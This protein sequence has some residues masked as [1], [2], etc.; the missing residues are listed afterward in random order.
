[1]I[2]KTI[3]NNTIIFMI[4]MFF[5]ITF[6][7]I[8]GEENTLI[9]VTTITATLMFLER[10]FTG[11]PL[12][13]TLKFIGINLLIGIGT[14]LIVVSN[15]WL[16]LIINFIVVFI[17]SYAFTYNLRQ[18]LYVPFGLQYLFL[19][20]T[21]VSTD[22]L[23]TRLLA[24]IFGALIIMLVQ[25]LF[26][27]NK[28]A[29]SGNKILVNVCEFIEN[30]VCCIKDKSNN[31][32]SINSISS[33]IDEFRTIVYDKRES[34]YY[35]TKEAKIK[36]NMSVALEGI[37]RILYNDNNKSINVMILDNLEELIEVSKEVIS[38]NSKENKIIQPN[39]YNIKSILNYCQEHE[40]NDLLNLQLLEGMIYLDDTLKELTKLDKKQY[41]VVD[42][43][44]DNSEICS[45]KNIKSFFKDTNSPKYCYAMRMAITMTIGLFLM[46]YFKLS[47][48]RWIL[49]TILS[50][51]TPLYETSK[52]K[53]RYR[54]E[55]T[56]IGAIIIIIL[57]SIF[58]TED[59]RLFIVMLS[60]YLQGYVNEYKHKTIFVTISAIGSAV[61]V[62][63][64]QA[65]TIERVVMVAIGTIV[66][67]IANRYLFPYNLEKS[68]YQLSKIYDVSIKKMFN[69]LRSL[70]EGKNNPEVIKNLF[71]TTSII[72]SKARINKQIYE[73]K[74]YISI[75]NERRCLVSNIYELYMWIYRESIDS[76]DLD[77]I[78]KYI[79]LLI[80]YRDCDITNK[81]TI[82]ETGIKESKNIKI[83]I[84]ISTIV[85]IFKELDRLNELVKSKEKAQI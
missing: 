38:I 11:S 48:G 53:I 72:E 33:S 23:G 85:V 78:I 15:M 1:M 36:L 40:I 29:T 42:K 81:V 57:F 9:G 39:S 27:K 24:L 28:L 8:F 5:V 70:L 60:G 74:N 49:F 64:V 54:I 14:S 68:N 76:K 59:S 6:K 55:A 82:L 77:K 75:V 43:I 52:H 79:K 80:E 21:P 45:K 50:L 7:S 37:S 25:L 13:N 73:D 71:V 31:C 35:L 46:E 66:A 83:K 58:K 32:D 84:I 20:T 10:D 4:V 56:L 19:L 63:N 51:T 34:D 2:K 44:G 47:E 62:G 41:K 16:E 65:L 12:K 17:F 61:I 22:K 3:I 26:N 69:E 18:P 30:K 67:I